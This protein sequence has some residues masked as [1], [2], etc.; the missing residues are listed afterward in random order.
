[1]PIWVCS[2]GALASACDAVAAERLHLVVR[3]RVFGARHRRR[4][5]RAELRAP[6]ATRTA[7]P[8][9]SARPGRSAPGRSDPGASGPASSLVNP[10]LAHARLGALR[11]R[12]W[13]ACAGSARPRVAD[14]DARA[15]SALAATR[16]CAAE[17][18]AIQRI[19]ARL[20]A[21][22][23]SAP[24][25]RAPPARWPHR[26]RPARRRRNARVALGSR[27]RSQFT[28]SNI[29]MCTMAIARPR[30]RGRAARRT[31]GVSPAVDRRVIETRRV[32][33]DLIPV[34]KTIHRL[35]RSPDRGERRDRDRRRLHTC[36]VHILRAGRRLRGGCQDGN[37]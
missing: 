16:S 18:A 33:G 24:A 34:A 10:I 37:G 8:R 1:M 28:A 22:E 31:R 7:S 26:A 23:T 12:R 21:T 4:R 25:C 3:A 13:R 32:D 9:P 29:A 35:A 2:G 36:A 14:R 17:S 19:E 15:A 5:R 30:G 11:S 6:S 27:R 20:S